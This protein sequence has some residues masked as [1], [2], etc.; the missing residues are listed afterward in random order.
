MILGRFTHITLTGM[1]SDLILQRLQKYVIAKAGKI[2]GLK[3]ALLLV[4]KKFQFVDS[5]KFW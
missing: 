5:Q 2:C 3:T 1:G 4:T